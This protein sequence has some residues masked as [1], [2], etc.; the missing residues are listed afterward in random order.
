MQEQ[1]WQPPQ[2]WYRKNRP[3]NDDLYFENMS[4][5]IF[6]A[7]L[8]WYVIDKKWSTI[9]TA[10]M[11]FS[12]EK[13]SRF[14]ESDVERLLKD[15]GVVRNRSKIQAL[16]LNAMQFKTIKQQY[17]SFQ[18]YLDSL[19]KSN[20]YAS[21][22]KELTRKFKRLGTPSASLFLYTVAEKISPW[23]Y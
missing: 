3:E 12:I 1:S 2:W 5:V 18:A 6:E 16:I 11:G 19:D 15:K 17:G 8:N 21:A 10:F 22:V 4:R 20:N 9:K 23:E 7:G 13:V 14:T